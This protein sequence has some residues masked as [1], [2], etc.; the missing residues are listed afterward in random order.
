MTNISWHLQALIT[1][2]NGGSAPLFNDQVA[3]MR[4][5]KI[6]EMWKP[7]D[8]ASLVLP[9]FE[10]KF[11]STKFITFKLLLAVGDTDASN[12][13][14]RWL[15][16]KLSRSEL[17]IPEVHSD[18]RTPGLWF[19]ALNVDESK[20]SHQ[21]TVLYGASGLVFLVREG[22]SIIEERG[23]LH[24]L[25]K[26]LPV[27][28]RLPLLLLYT[29][30]E[31][32]TE[33]ET[34]KLKASLGL[35]D[36]EGLRIGWQN[37]SPVSS[38]NDGGLYSDGFLCGGLV[39]LA[40]SAS[41][42]PNLRPIHVRELVTSN[43]DGHCKILMASSSS[44]VTPDRCI[45]IFNRSLRSAAMEIR[46]AVG[47]APPHWPPEEAESEVSDILPGFLPQQGWNEPDLLDPIH[48]ALHLAELPRFPTIEQVKPG[49]PTSAWENVRYQ[50]VLSVFSA[51]FTVASFLTILTHEHI[52]DLLKYYYTC[53]H[54]T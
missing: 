35:Y 9:L 23:R 48:Q 18:G 6:R 47:A 40:N 51:V 33:A 13:G 38:S 45:S 10:H 16:N 27:G 22:H 36:F 17:V 19:A 20:K 24:T 11:P 1:L 14:G 2:A 42:Q 50:K 41:S 31:R 15:S 30:R 49:T 26:I 43:L 54:C 8:V 52:I 5:E 12:M 34:E 4:S 37:V 28:A 44:N 21:A 7:L 29:P 25:V 53:E 39:W 3:R 32:N 46:K